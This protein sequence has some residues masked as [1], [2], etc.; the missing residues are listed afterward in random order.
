MSGEAI[1]NL[2]RVCRYADCCVFAMRFTGALHWQNTSVGLR[3]S[4]GYLLIAMGL[5]QSQTKTIAPAFEVASIKV[6][7]TGLVPDARSGGGN[8]SPEALDINCQTV[9]GLIQM[10]YVAFATGTRVTPAS[11]PIEGGPSWINSERYDVK[12]K[13]EGIQNQIL[14]HG[15][16]LQ[17][18]LEDRFKLKIHRETKDIPIY[19]LTV[20]K[21]GPKL[22][23]SKE[24]AC[25]LYDIAATFPPP[26]PPENPCRN[27]GTM[28]Q[29]IL[30]IDAQANTLDDFAKFVLGVM[31]RPVV[32]KTGIKGRFDFYIA[33]T[34]DDTSSPMSSRAGTA[35]GGTGAALDLSGPSI[36]TAL[37]EQLGLKLAPA[38]RP[39]DLLVIDSVERPSEN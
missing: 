14:M 17:S 34:P 13:A 2:W 36:F 12:A 15:P 37:Q 22:P 21:G 39:G 27:R 32:N 5:A 38:R 28:N 24:A 8:S 9:R 26:P 23:V 33:Y 30:T 25:N 10:A 1:E 29:G 3:L 35:G 31:D 7:R 11:T 16:M 6:C 18:L 19:A 20:A 4:Y